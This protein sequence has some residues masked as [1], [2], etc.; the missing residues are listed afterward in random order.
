MITPTKYVPAQH[1]TL[2][3]ASSI[4]ASRRDGTTVSDTWESFKAREASATFD[5]FLEALT[6]LHLLGLVELERGLLHWRTDAAV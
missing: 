3:R 4:L 2:G 5:T 6:L 1:T